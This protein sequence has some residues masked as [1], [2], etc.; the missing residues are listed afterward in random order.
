MKLEDVL[1]DQDLIKIANKAAQQF[2]EKLSQDEIK[3]CILGA[4]WSASNNYKEGKKTKFS[5][6]LYKGVFFECLKQLKM[7]EKSIGFTNREF[8][9]HVVP[10]KSIDNIELMDEINACQDPDIII[11]KFFFNSTLKD[12]AK[13]RGVSKETIR[14]K[15]KKNI[16]FLKSRLS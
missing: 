6:Y 12:M 16:N 13:K 14:F 5:T 15:L 3:N 2:S 4:M 7:N 11:E 10:Q 9:G 1:E 8:V